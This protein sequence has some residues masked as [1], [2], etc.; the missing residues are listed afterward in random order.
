MKGIADYV[1]STPAARRL[2][3]TYKNSLMYTNLQLIRLFGSTE[4]NVPAH[5]PHLINRR[6]M[7]R[8]E[9]SLSEFYNET[10][11][12]RFREDN[13]LQY[14]FLYFHFLYHLEARKQEEWNKKV[15]RQIDVND[16]GVLSGDE[17]QTL[18]LMV[19]EGKAS[20]E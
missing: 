3:D 1:D 2:S 5:M 20:E 11:H 13:D 12:H 7:E 10:I 15:W 18:N 14:A 4:R 19:N 16:D 8:I 9:T 17:L 6:V